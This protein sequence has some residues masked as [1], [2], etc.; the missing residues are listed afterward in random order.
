MDLYQTTIPDNPVVAKIAARR[1]LEIGDVT[2]EELKQIEEFE[3]KKAEMMMQQ[4][5]M[6]QQM[7]Q[8]MGQP[9]PQIQPM[10][11]PLT[12]PA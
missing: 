6:G 9:Q 7:G 11:K 1:T 5:M 12:Q 8:Q 2:A 10:A 4:P 3:E